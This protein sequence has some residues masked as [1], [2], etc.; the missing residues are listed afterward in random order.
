MRLRKVHLIL[1]FLLTVSSMSC[2]DFGKLE[3]KSDLPKLLNEVSG[4]ELMKG[5]D[6]IWMINDSNNSPKVYGYDLT[7]QKIKNVVSLQGVDNIDW[8][9]L[10]SD[11]IGNLYVGDFGNNN[12]DRK[13]LSIL[14]FSPD[15]KTTSQEVTPKITYFTLPDQTLF[16]PKRKNRNFDVES[17]FFFESN[18]YLFT[19]NRSSKFDGLT[20]IYRVPAT[21]GTVSA[22]LIGSFKTCDNNQNCQITSAAINLS[23]I[24]I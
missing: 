14:M 1:M 16:P 22:E 24:H 20:K 18:F 4:V 2:Q 3:L 19:R 12:N 23:L 21:E 6:R 13:N 17:F 10:A 9:D 8:E 11:T 7:S 5:N 15:L